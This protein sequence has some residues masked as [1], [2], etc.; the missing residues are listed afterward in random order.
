MYML[1]ICICFLY[2]K[3]SSL[4]LNNWQLIIFWLIRLLPD[5]VVLLE[6]PSHL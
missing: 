6:T 1:Y 3:T 4:Y 2:N 5:G